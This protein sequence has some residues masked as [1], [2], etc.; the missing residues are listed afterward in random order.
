M[1]TNPIETIIDV[2]TNEVVIR[3]LTAEETA[4]LAAEG[5][6]IKAERLAEIEAAKNAKTALLSKLGI[7]EDEAKL[8][9]S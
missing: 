1:M 6:R 8:L 5:E 4:E 3:E 9:L 7:T 2:E